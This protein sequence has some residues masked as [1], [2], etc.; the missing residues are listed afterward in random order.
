[1]YDYVIVGAGSAG[2]V[3]A[4]RLTEDPAVS[5][6]LLESGGADTAKEIHIPVAVSRLFK[7]EY[8]W[9]YY[10]QEQEELKQ[11]EI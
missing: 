9:S 8:D 1:M 5:V 7:S 10:T 11:R 4:H 2:C 3:L 6:L